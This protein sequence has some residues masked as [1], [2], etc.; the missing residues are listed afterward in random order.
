MCEVIHHLAA[1][2]ELSFKMQ[3]IMNGM[4][5]GMMGNTPQNGQFSDSGLQMLRIY[6]IILQIMSQQVLPLLLLKT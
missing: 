3:S 6:Y 5:P 1:F 4:M 2:F